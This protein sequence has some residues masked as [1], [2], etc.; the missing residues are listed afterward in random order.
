M[1]RIQPARKT[2]NEQRFK[3]KLDR[4]SVAQRTQKSTEEKTTCWDLYKHWTQN[5]KGQKLGLEQLRTGSAWNSE[6]EKSS[7]LIEGRSRPLVRPSPPNPLAL[8]R[9]GK[10]LRYGKH[11]PDSISKHF[12]PTSACGYFPRPLHFH[13]TAT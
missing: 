1:F 11:S 5:R 4:N 13:G 9:D 6:G 3:T 2:N 7:L 12:Y 10:A 8:K